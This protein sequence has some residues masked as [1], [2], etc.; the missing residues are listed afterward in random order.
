MGGS[1]A[2]SEMMLASLEAGIAFS[3]ASVTIVHGMSRPIGALFH[4]PH[5]LS[6]AVL[7]PDCMEFA[8]MGAPEKF[9]KVAEVMG[10]K[11]DGLS[12]M[13]AAKCAIDAIKQLNADL[14]I[15]HIRFGH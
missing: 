3:N 10:E 13:E 8:R 9:A 11:V 7:L 14:E 4:L 2:R 1:E 6:N 5:G 12:T 15:L